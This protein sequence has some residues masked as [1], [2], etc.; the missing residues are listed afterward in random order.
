MKNALKVWSAFT[1][2]INKQCHENQKSVDTNLIGLFCAKSTGICFYP[3]VDFV[4][5]GRFKISK[6]TRQEMANKSGCENY[7]EFYNG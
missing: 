5:A 7:G 1:K 4:E 2:F 3:S 6:S